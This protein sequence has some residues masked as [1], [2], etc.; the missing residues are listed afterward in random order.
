MTIPEPLLVLIISLTMLIGL[1]LGHYLTRKT[2][3]SRLEEIVKDTFTKGY[4]AGVR[5]VSESAKSAKP[6][7]ATDAD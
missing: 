4:L 5:A 6:A 7:K 1:W 3:E 2:L